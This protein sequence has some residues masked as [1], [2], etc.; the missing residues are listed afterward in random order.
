MLLYRD[1]T[2]KGTE[3][4]DYIIGYIQTDSKYIKL[5]RILSKQLERFIIEGRL[6]IYSFYI[7]VLT[8]G[9]LSEYKYKEIVSQFLLEIVRLNYIEQVEKLMSV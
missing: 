2:K 7:I 1:Y 9:L 8:E 3:Q 5:F 6:D 4:L